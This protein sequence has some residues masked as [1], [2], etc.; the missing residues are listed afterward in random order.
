VL[1]LVLAAA[2]AHGDADVTKIT[3]ENIGQQPLAFHVDAQDLG[4]GS[5]EFEIVVGSGQDS[6]WANHAGQL[7]AGYASVKK[8]SEK[9]LVPL[10]PKLWCNL[11][12]FPEQGILRY[13]FSL[14]V[15]WLADVRFEFHNCRAVYTLDIYEFPL[16]LFMPRQ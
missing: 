16:R 4:Q 3:P 5:V 14:P 8:R 12:E 7:L 1:G 15:D 6:I 13:R 9:E 11:R 10:R 2:S